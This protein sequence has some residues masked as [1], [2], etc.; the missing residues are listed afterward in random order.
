ML[1]DNLIQYTVA[2]ERQTYLSTIH[3][4]RDTASYLD[5]AAEAKKPVTNFHN[6][7][8]HSIMQCI[9]QISHHWKHAETQSQLSIE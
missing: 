8:R 2:R 6:R 9:T 1:G 3:I 4:E 7:T 5:K